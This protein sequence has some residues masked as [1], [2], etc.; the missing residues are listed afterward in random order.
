MRLLACTFLTFFLSI[1]VLSQQTIT[2]NDAT[3]KY[4]ASVDSGDRVF[5]RK[6]T[7]TKERNKG[8]RLV[9]ESKDTSEFVSEIK[10]RHVYTTFGSQTSTLEVIKIK[11]QFFC[12]ENNGKW[13]KSKEDCSPVSFLGA[14]VG[15]TTT[16]STT[17]IVMEGGT[18]V[19]VV[20]TI[21][22][23]K[24]SKGEDYDVVNEQKVFIN[25][26]GTIAREVFTAKMVGAEI[27]D[28]RWTT[29]YEYDPKDLKIEAPIK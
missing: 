20:A 16:K 26:D 11:T 4:L 19:E 9:E 22:V 21:S 6:V 7:L 27:F 18:K 28:F 17:E 13:K 8:G 10:S 5:P 25:L 24:S 12:R 3:Q 15:P 14:T 2:E 23:F 29:I 1:C